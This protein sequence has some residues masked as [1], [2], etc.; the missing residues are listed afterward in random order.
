MHKHLL[1]CIFFLLFSLWYSVV[2]WAWR[3][4]AHSNPSREQDPVGLT[5]GND[6]NFRLLCSGR[7]NDL[8]LRTHKGDKWLETI[9][10][11]FSQLSRLSFRIVLHNHLLSAAIVRIDDSVF[12]ECDVYTWRYIWT[13]FLSI[14]FVIWQHTR[15]AHTFLFQHFP[16]W[17]VSFSRVESH[18]LY[19]AITNECAGKKE[20][21]FVAVVRRFLFVCLFFLSSSL[22]PSCID[23]KMYTCMYA[24]KYKKSV[25]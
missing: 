11:G 7:R 20:T 18:N 25:G 9:G 10:K 4:I 1:S 21:G 24:Y 16:L 17:R 12:D 8:T 13:L 15:I 14:R 2:F 6:Q 19:L 23:M 5:V 3:V 22:P